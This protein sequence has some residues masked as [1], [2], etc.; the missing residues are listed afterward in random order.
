MKDYLNSLI[1]GIIFLFL[2]GVMV[3][4]AWLKAI[5]SFFDYKIHCLNDLPFFL[6]SIVIYIIANG[7]FAIYYSV[8]QFN[9]QNDN[10]IIIPQIRI[11]GLNLIL[12]V[13]LLLL[14]I[15]IRSLN[16]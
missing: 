12:I 7:M 1:I 4:A 2:L 16:L 3:D 10:R 6:F 11:I 13:F 15:L 8:I 14:F 9:L 5:P